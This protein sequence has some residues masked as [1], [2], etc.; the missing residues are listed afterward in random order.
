MDERV[1]RTNI[2]LLGEDWCLAGYAWRGSLIHVLLFGVEARIT[3]TKP[4]KRDT[5]TN[6]VGLCL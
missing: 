5:P 3:K 4:G 6:L 2:Q 1:D